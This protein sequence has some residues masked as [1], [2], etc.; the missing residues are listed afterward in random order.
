MTGSLL[1]KSLSSDNRRKLF[2]TASTW[3][4]HPICDATWPEMFRPRLAFD[5]LLIICEI[6]AIQFSFY[7]G[8][9]LC[10]ML[11]DFILAI[12]FSDE[13]I[14]NPAVCS[15]A[16]APGQAQCFGVIGGGLFTALLFTLLEGRSRK[17][18]DF[19]TTTFVMHLFIVSVTSAFPKFR[20][21]WLTFFIAWVLSMALAIWTSLRI[22]LRSIDLGIAM[23]AVLQKT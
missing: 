20:E 16:T 2:Q 3:R 23:P 4:C 14:F 19:M 10:S 18:P 13:Q 22:E 8:H 11:V 17:A 5:S 9:F 1:K 15:V 21:W 12:P 7:T 6:V